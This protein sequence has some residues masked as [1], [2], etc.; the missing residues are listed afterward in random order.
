MS[1][2]DLHVL[3]DE[4]AFDPAPSLEELYHYHVP[5]DELVGA[6]SCESPLR[7]ALLR[8]EQVAL[9]GDSGS[10]KSSVIGHVLGPLVEGVAPLPV[11]VAVEGPEVAGDP[12]LFS[13]HLVRTIARHVEHAMPGN[14]DE[15]RKAVEQS[16]PTVPERVRRRRFGGTIGWLRTKF[17]LASELERVTAAHPRSSAEIFEQAKKMLRIIESYDLRPV[18][19]F[20][21]TDKWFGTGVEDPDRYLEGFFGRVVRLIAEEYGVAAVLAVHHA[22]LEHP[23]YTNAAGF[24]ETT[25]TVPR[26]PDADSLGRLLERRASG[27]KVFEPEALERLFTYYNQGNESDLRQRVLLIVHTALAQACDEDADRVRRGH[28]ELAIAE[29]GEPV[30]LWRRIWVRR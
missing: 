15:A 1:S 27:R 21:D 18:L 9:L 6:T 17:E 28:I 22:Y 25:I 14:A 7:R 2:A 8:G 24:V 10:G 20:D 29:Y 12:A 3:R 19:V 13:S 26:L 23:A 11:P 4:H 5:F 16:T 30:G